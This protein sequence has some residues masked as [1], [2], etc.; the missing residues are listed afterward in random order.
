MVFLSDFSAILGVDMLLYCALLMI[1]IASFVC[2]R[3]YHPEIRRAFA[4]PIKGLWL[5]PFFLPCV[6]VSAYVAYVT[7]SASFAA[8]GVMILVG[9]AMFTTMH[10]YRVQSPMAF[11]QIA[12]AV[13]DVLETPACSRLNTPAPSHA[14]SMWDGSQHTPS[15]SS[16]RETKDSGMRGET[17]VQL[18]HPPRSVLVAPPAF[19]GHPGRA[20]LGVICAAVFGSAR[21]GVVMAMWLSA[22]VPS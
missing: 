19:G 12:T 22:W 15:M 5:I 4:V 14:G 8:A 16:R 20:S 6:G 10:L 21:A 9:M 3:V 7:P 2:L 18:H 17:Q 1:E 13:P 11:D